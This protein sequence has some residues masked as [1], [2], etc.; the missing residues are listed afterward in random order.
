M[1]VA[2]DQVG[3]S[4]LMFD[5]HTHSHTYI[6]TPSL[7]PFCPKSSLTP[8]CHTL[9]SHP[10]C[11]G[12]HARARMLVG[13]HRWSHYGPGTRA[14]QSSTRASPFRRLPL[15][16]FPPTH[17]PQS[18]PQHPQQQ[19]PQ[20][21]PSQHSRL[22]VEF[23]RDSLLR[24]SHWG[25]TTVDHP[26]GASIVWTLQCLHSHHPHLLPPLGFGNPQ[27]LLLRRPLGGCSHFTCVVNLGK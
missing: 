20:P 16:P 6:D 10:P 26:E 3:L 24:Y 14:R 17:P 25:T 8:F 19:Y 13:P 22:C 15:Y 23:F 27:C 11:S 4:P 9:L 7:T 18:F 21:L 2:L 5:T 1:G 12:G